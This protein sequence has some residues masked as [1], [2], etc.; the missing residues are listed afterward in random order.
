MALSSFFDKNEIT[1]PRLKKMFDE[2]VDERSPVFLSTATLFYEGD[3]IAIID[4]IFYITN[5]LSREEAI[6]YFKGKNLSLKI[7]Q[8]GTL[9]LGETVLTGIGRYRNLNIMK[10]RVP[11]VLM[12]KDPR[13]AYRLRTFFQTPYISFSYKQKNVARGRITD[14]SMSGVGFRPEAMYSMK[15]L[16]LST[17]MKVIADI[18]LEDNWKITTT[19]VIRH[20]THNKVGIEYL[21]LQEKEKDALFKFIVRMRKIELQNKL[22]LEGKRLTRIKNAPVS[23]TQEEAKSTKPRALVFFLKDRP[24]ADFLE[25]VLHRRFDVFLKPISVVDMREAISEVVPDLVLIELLLKESSEVTRRKKIAAAMAGFVPYMLYGEKYSPEFVMT[26]FNDEAQRRQL[27]DLT[28][29]STILSYKKIE[30]FFGK[31]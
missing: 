19:A 23:T 5:N 31:K 25:K 16:A 2:A 10:L 26:N 6:S 13:Q 17:G 11:S 24:L 8:G 27:L 30:A 22:A 1:G 28:G 12:N 14:I 15:E 7:A 3:V 20:V 21:S 9:Y 4:E 18:R 29:R